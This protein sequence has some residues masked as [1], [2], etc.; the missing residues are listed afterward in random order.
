MMS[1]LKNIEK[2]FFWRPDFWYNYL[3]K[4]IEINANKKLYVNEEF[5]LTG[6]NRWLN[7]NYKIS[8]FE[9]H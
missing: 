5:I 2:L 1:S 4:I 3:K 6:L 8:F 7:F 9:L